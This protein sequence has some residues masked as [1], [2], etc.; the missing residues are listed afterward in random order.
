[1]IGVAIV[2]GRLMDDRRGTARG[3][4][5]SGTIRR[6]GAACPDDR[7]RAGPEHAVLVVEPLVGDAGIVGE[8]AGARPA[9]LVED[10]ARAAV[11]KAAAACRARAARAHRMSIRCCTPAGG[12]TARRRRIT[13]P[14]RFVIVPSS[15]AHCADGSTTSARLAV[16]DRKKSATTR[17]SSARS[18]SLDADAVR[19]R[20][21]DVRSHD[22]HR[23]HA[24]VRADRR[25]SAGRPTGRRP[26][27]AAGRHA[28]DRGDV[29]RAPRDRRCA[30][31]RAADRLSARARVRPVRFPVR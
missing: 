25:Q 10:V 23:A 9:Q 2:D 15:S 28:P 6:T 20:H 5:A 4:W 27:I 29:L 21:G 1:M 12:S 30:G 31:S 13:R 18:R 3:R 11:R 7:R 8:P 16:S 17:Q 14:S 26:G 22:E 19:R 24:A